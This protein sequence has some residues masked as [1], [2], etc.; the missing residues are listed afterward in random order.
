MLIGLATVIHASATNCVPSPSG[1][2]GWWPGDGNASDIVGTNNGT[3][4]GG[5][6]ASAAG[7]VGTAFIFDGT[8]GYVQ[9][10]DSPVFR[11]TN[12]T[13]EAWV[14]FSSLDSATVGAELGHQYIVFKQNSRS[15]N[16]EGF[17]LGKDRLP[18]INTNGDV[19]YFNVS[20][21]AGVMVEVDSVTTVQ[22]GA[23]YHVAAVRGSNYLQLYVNGQLEAQASVSFPQNYGAF[24]LF[25]GTSG[26]SYW[27][28]KM[29]GSLDEVSLYNRA[30]S[31]NEIAAIYAAGDAGKCKE[32]NITA[33]PQ[34]QTVIAG[35][36]MSI[37]VT[38]TGTLPL[39]YRWQSNGV[40]LANG[41]KV[42]GAT[43]S[44]LSLTSVQTND[45]A[46]YR[47]VITNT[48]NAVTSAVAVLAVVV[49]P[50][51]ATNP[52]GQTVMAGTNVAF[53][54]A[55]S[56]TG[57]LSY[58]WRR[59]NAN[60]VNGGQLGGV[61]SATLTINDAQPVNAGSYSVVVTN[62]AGSVTGAVATLTVNGP[63]NCL[64]P[65][66]GLVGWW[67]GDGS[68]NDLVGA[69]D[70]TLNGSA[71]AS[72]GAVVGIGFGF[73]GTNG[74]VL[75][76]DAL[77]LRPTNFTIETWVRFDSLVATNTPRPTQQYIVFKQN[78]RS[79]E[80]EA[81]ELAQDRYPNGDIISWGVT[82]GAGQLVSIG[83]VSVVSTGVWYHLAAVR[84]PD[85]LQL[86]INGQL[87]S[88]TNVYFP[89]DYGNHPL[90][91]G[92]SGQ[93]WWD[94]KLSGMLDEVSLYNRV[95]SSN[96][97]TAIYL[98]WS[99]GKCKAP[100]ILTQPLSQ[101]G[102]LGGSA[103]FTSAV[104]GANP[105]NYQW[106]K[107]G[108]PIAGATNSL[109]VMTNLQTTDVGSYQVVVT[110]SLGAVTSAVATLSLDWSLRFV[111]YFVN[112]NGLFQ[113][114]LIGPPGSNVIIQGWFQGLP[115]T[116]LVT[117]N[118]SNGVIDFMDAIIFPDTNL[119]GGPS[120][121]NRSYRARLAP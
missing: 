80:F 107:G 32:V 40:D 82:S 49:A 117:N 90:C 27:D 84:G 116:S 16:F 76:P 113:T 75:I 37:S 101:S 36:N 77:V 53:T 52:A 68:A 55:A 69:N 45:S 23:W 102:Y 9:I 119:P 6:T 10:P 11:P 106:Q 109:L 50:S 118:A 2:V 72:A 83:S 58:Q 35:A 81:F 71:T 67:P 70:G 87:E 41:G 42:S 100:A 51:I 89:Q 110:N 21:A 114:R 19:L 63:T 112:S 79:T 61:T 111:K 95:L 17:G 91:F 30:L 98:A 28:G 103:T 44:V 85:F 46:N 47:V 65:P 99:A 3:L 105:L 5:A 20:S 108:V 73:D 43:T 26:Q 4:Q 66:A 97:I 34:S 24:P 96:E 33:Q 8:D 1:L 7:R 57:P 29:N 92:T 86:Y 25:F 12:L 31:S 60:L 39:S 121:T 14:C 13:V 78:S 48:V 59:N 22:T 38:A 18:E 56:G 62:V 15:S 104:L 64:S 120:S 88:Q 74:S 93:S 94:H 54:V 115:W